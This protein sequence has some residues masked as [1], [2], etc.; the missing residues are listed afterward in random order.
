MSLNTVRLHSALCHIFRMS[1][2]Y[3]I[4]KIFRCYFL[5]DSPEKLS[6]LMCKLFCNKDVSQ[7]NCRNYDIDI[8]LA[9][10]S[11]FFNKFNFKYLEKENSFIIVSLNSD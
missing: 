7:N 3:K 5:R 8:I 9:F 4:G 11:I 10:R 6:C 1:V 2:A